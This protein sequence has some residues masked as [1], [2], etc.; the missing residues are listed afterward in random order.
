MDDAFNKAMGKVEAGIAEL[1]RVADQFAKSKDTRP[2]ATQV[3]GL[4]HAVEDLA[5]LHNVF[6]A[7]KG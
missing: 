4:K 5:K 7:L 3:M 2:V 6:H 1:N